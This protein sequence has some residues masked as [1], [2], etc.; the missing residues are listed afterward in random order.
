MK[1]FDL[2]AVS[3]HLQ[4]NGV[5]L[6]KTASRFG[7]N[8]RGMSI[9]L[10]D[11]EGNGVELQ[12]TGQEIARRE[13]F[14]GLQGQQAGR[15]VGGSEARVLP[16]GLAVEEHCRR[17]CAFLFGVLAAFP[18]CFGA[19]EA[20]RAADGKQGQD[21]DGSGDGAA[22]PGLPGFALRV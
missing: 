14:S 4:D 7:A 11:P 16:D 5:P 2:D 13:E 6:G 3:R 22:A 19:E 17:A 15:A 10:S 1:D 8:G 20:I 12:G 21:E 9:Y 18:Q